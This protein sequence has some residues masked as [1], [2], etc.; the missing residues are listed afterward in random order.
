[1]PWLNKVLT[2]YCL[3]S[4]LQPLI[5]TACGEKWQA[6]NSMEQELSQT[7]VRGRD[8]SLTWRLQRTSL[9]QR[10]LPRLPPHHGNPDW[11]WCC[12]GHC[13]WW[14]SPWPCFPAVWNPRQQWSE[15]QHSSHTVTQ[16]RAAVSLVW[17]KP[18]SAMFSIPVDSVYSKLIITGVIARFMWLTSA[19]QRSS[20]DVSIK[21]ACVSRV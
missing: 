6:T 20:S 14:G 9:Q 8:G 1:M 3:Q 5:L 12:G 2:T 16:T 17:E 13:L 7:S 10:C 4:P 15:M 11:P 21:A 19:V 18:R